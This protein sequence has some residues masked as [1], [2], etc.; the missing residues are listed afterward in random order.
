MKLSSVNARICANRCSAGP[1]SSPSGTVIADR[2]P[3]R[4]TAYFALRICTRTR[5]MRLYAV[6]ASASMMFAR[7]HGSSYSKDSDFKMLIEVLLLCM[8]LEGVYTELIVS[9]LGTWTACCS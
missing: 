4:S 6:I 2:K 1:A 9:M 8:L 5:A 7:G 3:I